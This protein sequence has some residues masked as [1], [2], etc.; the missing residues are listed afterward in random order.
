MANDFQ[1][2]Q[3]TA[4]YLTL[5]PGCF[6]VYSPRTAIAR[7]RHRRATGPI[8]KIVIKVPFIDGTL[9]GFRSALWPR[10]ARHDPNA[11]RCLWA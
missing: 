9:K 11:G 1:E 3:G 10:L 6:A 7:G 2:L 8:R 4:E 5:R